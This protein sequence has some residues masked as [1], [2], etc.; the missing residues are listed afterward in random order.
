[1]V[2]VELLIKNV[3]EMN[4]YELSSSFKTFP[5]FAGII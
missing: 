3:G 2:R 4:K 1:M 5:E